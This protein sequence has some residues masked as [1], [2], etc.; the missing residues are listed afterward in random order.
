MSFSKPSYQKDMTTRT[1][2]NMGFSTREE[3]LTQYQNLFQDLKIL[4]S[5]AEYIELKDYIE[6]LK[7]QQC[8]YTE[9]SET[10]EHSID[11]LKKSAT[12][13]EFN[14]TQ[15]SLKIKSL[16]SDIPEMDALSYRRMTE[17]NYFQ[18]NE[19]RRRICL[20]S[21]QL[22]RLEEKQRYL[23]ESIVEYYT[24]IEKLSQKLTLINEC[25]VSIKDIIKKNKAHLDFIENSITSLK[26]SLLSVEREI[27]DYDRQTSRYDRPKIRRH[28]AVRYDVPHERF[29]A[30]KDEEK[31]QKREQAR[32]KYIEA[33]IQRMD[34]EENELFKTIVEEE[35]RLAE[36]KEK[37]YEM[38]SKN[39]ARQRELLGLL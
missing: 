12:S 29:L 30:N 19:L 11:L 14:L 25:N 38:R 28:N 24:L 18:A 23:N 31:K 13:I 4:E 36:H 5:S 34:H 21:S 35:K 16:K 9:Q 32:K 8:Y 17:F 20:A 10:L 22:S 27:K 6:W 3:L 7:K 1:K 15:I 33:E 37:L 2:P 26:N 39:V